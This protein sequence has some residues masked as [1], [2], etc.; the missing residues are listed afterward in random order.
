[1]K[2]TVFSF[3]LIIGIV[4]FLSSCVMNSKTYYK[5]QEGSISTKTLEGALVLIPGKTHKL[6]VDDNI[7]KNEAVIITFENDTYEGWFIVKEWNG[8]DIE[9]KLYGKKG[10]IWSDEKSRLTIPAGNSSFIFDVNYGL[11][12]F[13]DVELKY[14]L[15]EGK[16]YKVKGI[17]KSLGRKK[18]YE[19]FV[20]L[21]DVTKKS[22]LLREWKMG[23]TGK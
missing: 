19:V 10:D 16:E 15:E 7:P 11:S 20:G 8:K 17:L 5:Y 22:T 1:M 14:N 23:E 3:V 4:V 13:K 2:K 18:G 21:Y 12:R 9:V 6:V